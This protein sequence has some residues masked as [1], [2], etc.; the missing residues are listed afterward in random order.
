[1]R[2]RCHTIPGKPTI[3]G[4]YIAMLM[5]AICIDLLKMIDLIFSIRNPFRL[6]N[7]SGMYYFGVSSSIS[8]NF[9]CGVPHS[10][11][12]NLKLPD[13]LKIRDMEVLQFQIPRMV[14][15]LQIPGIT[16]DHLYR[17]ELKAWFP[18][19]QHGPNA[20]KIRA[21]WDHW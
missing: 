8:S 6:G 14:R 19:F 3:K 12:F 21:Q 16:G 18:W 1:M 11:S 4:N 13:G 15:N 5:G 7:L 9:M 20:P 2:L 10:R 17:L